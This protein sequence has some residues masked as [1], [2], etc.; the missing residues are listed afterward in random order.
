MGRGPRG[1]LRAGVMTASMGAIFSAMRRPLLRRLLQAVGPSPGQGP[2]EEK[3]ESGFLRCEFTGRSASGKEVRG[4]L[5]AKGDPGNRVTTVMVC[6]A[7]LALAK[8]G[9]ALPGG[10]GFGGVLTPVTG[11]GSVLVTRL[12]DAGMQV[13]VLD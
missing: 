9:A 10:P 1:A 13:Q 2:S 4:V 11:L 3:I 8:N 12:R 7:A 6:E 5:Y